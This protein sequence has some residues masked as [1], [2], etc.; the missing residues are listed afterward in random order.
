[1]NWATLYITGRRDFREEVRRKLEGS[2]LD[3]MPGYVDGSAA[4]GTYDLYWI[5]E[6]LPLKEFKEA[7]GSKLIWKY[8]LRFHTTLEGFI[9]TLDKGGKSSQLS[10]DEENLLTAMR[11]SA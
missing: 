10:E 6:H 11:K 1:M 8:R 5:A 2:K 7:I 9:Q 3:F 4:T